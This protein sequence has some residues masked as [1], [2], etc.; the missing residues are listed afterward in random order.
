MGDGRI[1]SDPEAYE[2]PGVPWVCFFEP[3]TGVALHGTYWHTNYGL[4]MS[5]ALRQLKN[6]DARFL[7]R[8]TTPVAEASSRS[9]NGYGTLVIVE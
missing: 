5:H 3:N 2:L 4:Q 1:T 8:W 7:Y 9:T 6:E